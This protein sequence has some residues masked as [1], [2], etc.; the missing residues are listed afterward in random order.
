MKSFLKNLL[1]PVITNFARKL[2]SHKWLSE[3]FATWE[4]AEE[5]SNGYDQDLILKKVWNSTQSVLA[6]NSAF[7]RDSVAFSQPEYSW[8]LL[9]A[10]LLASRNSSQTTVL[11]F[12]GSLGSSYFQNQRFFKEIGGLSWIV[13]E[14]NHFVALG[15]EK[16]SPKFLISFVSSLNE[17]SSPPSIVLFCSVLQYLENFEETV[18]QIVNLNPE[19]IFVDRT[20]FS[21]AEDQHRIHVQYVPKEIY[22]ASYPC[23]VFG[24]QSLIKLFEKNYEILSEHVCSDDFGPSVKFRGFL[25]RKKKSNS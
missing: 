24:Y 8:P 22:P 11:D 20:P 16:I 15:R 12:G 1:P 7:E 4:E 25:L 2:S 3:S 13:L 19:Y 23:R 9:S 6:G 5:H 17:L 21:A 14:Q 10:V 18:T